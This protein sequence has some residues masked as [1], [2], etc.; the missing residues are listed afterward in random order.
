MIRGGSCPGGKQAK[1][2]AS[3]FAR[4]HMK[5]DRQVF[6]LGIAS[7]SPSHRPR[8]EADSGMLNGT[9]AALAGHP[10]R[11]RVR[12][13]IP[14][15]QSGSPH[16]PIHPAGRN[17]WPAG[18]LSNGG[19]G[20]NCPIGVNAER[21]FFVIAN[22]CENKW[23]FD[24]EIGGRR[25]PPPGLVGGKCGVA[26]RRPPVIRR[27]AWRIRFGRLDGN[28]GRVWRVVQNGLIRL[29]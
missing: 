24:L 26:E 22:R 21:I 8:C 3:R 9:L 17:I 29:A 6:R 23:L 25:S 19:I 1:P 20:S 13:G 5:L 18:N 7:R 14:G 12:G 27:R 10:L 15:N 11:R 2:T 4:T 16:F 28:G